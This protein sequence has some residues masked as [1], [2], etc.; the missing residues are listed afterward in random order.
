[1]KT[2][3]KLTLLVV[4]TITFFASI[5]FAD[6]QSEVVNYKQKGF[7]FL[8]S[9]GLYGTDQS[10]P[11]LLPKVDLGVEYQFNSY[12]ELNSKITLTP[13]VQ[14]VEIGS[15]INLLNTKWSPF[16]MGSL[17]LTRDPF[18]PSY[19]GDESHLIYSFGAGVDLNINERILLFASLRIFDAPKG[20]QL[21]YM[22]EFGVQF[23]F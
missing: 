2:T 10:I 8:V 12:I 5:S 14:S 15:K 16:V 17:G 21:E 20:T 19:W 4:L 7:H 3:F 9:G 18:V 23:L 13:L 6:D 22:P 1:M 11:P